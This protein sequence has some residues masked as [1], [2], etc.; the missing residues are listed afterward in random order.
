VFPQR[1]VLG[2]PPM[3]IDP[4]RLA[5]LALV[6]LVLVF[7][8][9]PTLIVIP[10]SFS[11]SAFLEFPP[12]AW[13]LRWY[14]AYF[15]SEAWRQ[16]TWVSVRAACMTSVLS[17]ILGTSCAYG[18][19]RAG[20]RL[21]GLLSGIV[22][23]PIIVPVILV[24]VS[25]FMLYAQLR[26]NA[27]MTGLVLAHTT[28]ALPFVVLTVLGGLSHYDWAQEQAACSLGA[29]P[30]RAFFEITLP[31][32]KRSVISGAFLALIFSI[33][34]VVVALF[35]SGGDNATLTRRMFNSLRDQI[36][37][38]IAAISTCLIVCSVTVMGLAHLL[39]S[40]SRV[41]QT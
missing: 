4:V 9:L 31:Q 2:G 30:L 34:E 21:S 3:K 13:S 7:L 6:S 19:H 35:I 38:T 28:L 23:L 17:T 22:L 16:A 5:L 11:A 25:L 18:L 15:T 1:R 36:D 27:T 12:R 41:R 40:R 37:P 8:I 29:H 33:D 10:M 32:I 26:L 20:L 24:G 39:A 14:Q